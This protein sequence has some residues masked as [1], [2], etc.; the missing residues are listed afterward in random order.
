MINRYQSIKL[1]IKI[2]IDWFP[3]IDGQLMAKMLYPNFSK[4]SMYQ[5]VA[6][7]PAVT[8]LVMST[9]VNSPH[10]RSSK[11]TITAQI[12]TL[13]YKFISITKIC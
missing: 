8:V 13:Q 2:G 4:Q 12:R 7:N 6:C 11:D 10:M 3:L 1:V 9:K 5:S